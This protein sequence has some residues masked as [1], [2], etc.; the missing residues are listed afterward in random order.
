MQLLLEL[1]LV[2]YME[3]IQQ[4]VQLGKYMTFMEFNMI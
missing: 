2:I 4:R 1:T 3:M